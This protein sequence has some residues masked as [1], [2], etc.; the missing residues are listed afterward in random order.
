[1]RLEAEAENCC[2]STFVLRLDG[3]PIGKYERRHWRSAFDVSLL[4]RVRLQLVKTSWLGSEFVLREADSE[5]ALGEARPAGTFTSSWDLELRSGAFKLE[6]AGWF[7]NAFVVRHGEME[8]ARVIA[9]GTCARGW[10]LQYTGAL[11]REDALLIGLI[12]HVL[13]E[14]QAAAAGA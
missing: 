10:S 12:Y 3:Q 2:S 8:L 6:R 9:A 7:D 11:A 4:G 1:M 13:R 5:A 14:R